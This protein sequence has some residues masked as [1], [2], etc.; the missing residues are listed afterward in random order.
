MKKTSR[1][2]NDELASA[3]EAV[4]DAE[5]IVEAAA[6]QVKVAKDAAVKLQKEAYKAERAF[7]EASEALTKALKKANTADA[8]YKLVKKAL[9]AARKKDSKEH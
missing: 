8:E 7:K 9:D 5:T 2:L 6:G 4:N 1:K 3:L